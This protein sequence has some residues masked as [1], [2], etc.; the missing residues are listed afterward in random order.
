MKN[1]KYLNTSFIKFIN[2]KYNK[3]EKLT[4]EETNVSDEEIIDN[5]E[6]TD[7]VQ[8]EE[9]EDTIENLI[10]EFNEMEKKYKTR[11]DDKIYNKK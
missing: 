11:T 10:K 5:I 3:D 9:D 1:K 7:D 4:D 6:I 2:E 8:E